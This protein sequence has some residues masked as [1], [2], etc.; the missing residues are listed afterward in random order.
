M[1]S[2][3]GPKKVHRYTIEL[4]IQA[5]RLALHPDIQHRMLLTRW[6]FTRSCFQK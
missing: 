2:P 5:V 1:A 6:I 3:I 4:K